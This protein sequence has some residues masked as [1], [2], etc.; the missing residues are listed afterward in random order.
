[1]PSAA[2]LAASARAAGAHRDLGEAGRLAQDLD[3]AQLVE[4]EVALALG[5]VHLELQVHHLGRR[6]RLRAPGAARAAG[7]LRGG[8]LSSQQQHTLPLR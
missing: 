3:V 5:A 4:V 6:R 1:M 7:R 2:P 8:R